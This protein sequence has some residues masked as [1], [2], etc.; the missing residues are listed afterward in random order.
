[1]SCCVGSISDGP[2][3]EWQVRRKTVKVLVMV[4][5]STASMALVHGVLKVIPELGEH[6]GFHA[7]LLLALTLDHP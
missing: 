7:R 3:K 6:F 5:H 4:L 1:M 2:H